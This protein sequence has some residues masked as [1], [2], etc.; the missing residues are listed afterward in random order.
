MGSDAL[1]SH[2]RL[3]FIINES[4]ASST[5]Y[6]SKNNYDTGSCSSAVPPPETTNS[7]EVQGRKKRRKR[8]KA[9]KNKE[10]AETQRMTHI[11]VERNRR[12]QMNEHLAM[13]RSL[14]PDSYV[15]RGDQ[16]SIV[17]GAIEFVKEL[18]HILQSL[19][20]NKA[21]SQL[22]LENKHTHLKCTTTSR[23]HDDAKQPF[24][25]NTP[26]L[27]SCSRHNPLSSKYT[28]HRKAAAVADVQVTLVEAHASIRIVSG[29][30]V[31]Q[32]SKLVAA[33][34]SLF[35]NVLHLNLTT[36]QSFI[37][38]SISAKVE[39]GS[40]LSSAEDISAALHHMLRIL[41][42]EEEASATVAATLP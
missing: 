27:C 13:L 7:L 30:R 14:M 23:D 18:E 12:R 35:L 11:A 25:P 20:A 19:E 1:S 9:C 29:R 8:P 10:E 3:N 15:Q 2:E 41:I 4:K 38:Y 17:G 16:A 36:S 34:H 6:R 24:P 26:E 22:L 42:E 40:P 31:R 33:F 5:T 37:L 32:L 21:S 28:S 39:E